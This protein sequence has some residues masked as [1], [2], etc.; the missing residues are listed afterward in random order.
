MKIAI[1]QENGRHEKNR[2]FRECFSMQRS[3]Q[4]L[5][6]V[7]DVW[8]LGH[9]NYEKELEWDSYDTI[10]NLENYDST[11][12]LP[13]LSQT[14]KPKKLLWSIDA[15]CRGLNAYRK[16][17]EK[18]NYNLILQA[19]KDF[20]D[21]NSCWFPNCYDSTLIERNNTIERKSFL[22][23]CGSLLNRGEILSFL[24][25]K[26]DLRKDIW[27][28][29]RDMVKAVNS[30]QI[31]FNINLSNDINYRSFETLGCG[32]ALLTNKNYQYDELGFIDGANCITYSS[33]EEMVKKLDYYKNNPKEVSQIQ[34][35]SAELAKSHT[36]DVRASTLG[37]IICEI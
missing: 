11:G 8:G 16:I 33:V 14:S 20:V 23:F 10:L 21:N 30:Y 24:E 37:D 15:H 29:G 17:F 4:K 25:N 19:T 12:W 5:N 2:D 28:L 3:L 18:G 35:K 27:V 31:H 26:Y 32:T 22:G 7:V 6:F 1:I 36:Y 34:K 13:D 9:D